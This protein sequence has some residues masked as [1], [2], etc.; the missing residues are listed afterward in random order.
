VRTQKCWRNVSFGSA[1]LN[2][3]ATRGIPALIAPPLRVLERAR[4][5]LA[6]PMR[7]GVVLALGDVARQAEIGPGNLQQFR[8]LAGSRRCSA[9]R[10]QCRAWR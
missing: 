9:V 2:E 3:A 7:G 8:A 6:R 1:N 10:T 4:I 5:L